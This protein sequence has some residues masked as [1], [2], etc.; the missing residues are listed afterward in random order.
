[1]S[2]VESVVERLLASDN[3]ENSIKILAGFIE[4]VG[5]NREV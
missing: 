2:S 3:E 5:C 1:M 4:E